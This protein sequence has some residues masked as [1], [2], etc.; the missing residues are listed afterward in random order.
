MTAARQLR[1]V[2]WATGNIGSRALRAV[3]EHPGLTLAGVYV[4]SPDKAGADAGELCGIEPV[5]V[6]ATRSLEEV[7]ALGADCVLYMPRA[8]DLDEVCRLLESGADIVTTRG[9]FHRPQSL[10]PAVRARVEAA[11]ERGGTSIHSTGS[12]PG[13]ITEAVPLTLASIQRRLDGLTIE[14]FADLSRR[15]SPGLLFD[16]MLFGKPPEAFEDGRFSFGR[17]SFGP[18]LEL[19]AEALSM[20]LDSVEADGEVATARR[21]I[22]IAAGIVRAGTVAAQRMTVSGLRGGKP[23]LRF[24][25]TWYCTAELEPT[26]DVRPTGWHVEVEGDAPLDV[27]LRFAVPLERMAEFSPAYTANRAVNAVPH[28]CAAAPGIRTVVDLPH[29]LSVLG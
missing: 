29:I 1:V 23:V 5:G 13:F 12:S 26:W 17:V 27:D 6:A 10:D 18:S 22:E 9:E 3:I 7:V 21:D 16:I 20:P 25:A 8:C 28:V 2:Q 14:E 11:C 19:V 15:D 4:H 24:R